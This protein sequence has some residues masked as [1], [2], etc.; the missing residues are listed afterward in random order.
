MHYD[1]E[2][3]V[4]NAILKVVIYKHETNN[5][6]EFFY[7]LCSVQQCQYIHP[8]ILESFLSNWKDKFKSQLESLDAET[9]YVVIFRCKDPENSQTHPYETL[10]LVWS[11]CMNVNNSGN[12]FLK[13]H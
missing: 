3:A 1:D 12:D 13:L 9:W 5:P 6:D 8:Y 2:E 10:P 4:K 7:K 11:D